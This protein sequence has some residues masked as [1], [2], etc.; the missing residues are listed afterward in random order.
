VAHK[1]QFPQKGYKGHGK[2]L[3][4][5]SDLKGNAKCFDCGHEWFDAHVGWAEMPQPQKECAP[6]VGV[7]NKEI[8][9]SRQVPVSQ[10]DQPRRRPAGWC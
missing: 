4:V 10:E 1:W 8:P 5:F 9:S 3:G 6:K 2:V 7:E